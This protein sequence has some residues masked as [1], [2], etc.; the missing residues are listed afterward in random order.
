MS[1]NIDCFKDSSPYSNEIKK[2]YSLFK[3]NQKKFS[4]DIKCQI[5]IDLYNLYLDSV[6]QPKLALKKFKEGL[7]KIFDVYS[8]ENKSTNLFNKADKKTNKEK[9][10]GEHYYELFSKF[11]YENIII[12]P[13][14]Y[15]RK[16]FLRNKILFKNFRNKS[17]IDLGCGIGRYSFALKDMGFKNVL[18]IDFSKRNIQY[19]KSLSKKYK[20]NDV[21]FKCMNIL[22]L[23]LKYKFDFAFSYGSFHHTRSID[24]CVKKMKKILK[25]KSEGV[26]YVSHKG[27]MRWAVVQLCRN[28]LKNVKYKKIY[29]YLNSTSE[30]PKKKYLILD[31]ILVPINKLSTPQ[32]VE[33]I[34][35]NNN[36]KKFKRFKRGSN[37]DD[38]ENIYQYKNK[39]STKNLF[40][41]F[42]YGE[43]RYYFWINEK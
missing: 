15:L 41:I 24:M 25:K 40:Y 34:L 11:T 28:I 31:H 17:A 39:I 32:S 23:N 35:K 13:K 9:I 8:L 12:E 18:G 19:A 26:I 22:N 27:G 7:I 3:K 10:T 42:G 29:D 6:K 16:R 36:I 1:Y 2:I 38:I 43:N 33:K 4:T 20:I 37:V 21:E 14:K 30:T 5:T